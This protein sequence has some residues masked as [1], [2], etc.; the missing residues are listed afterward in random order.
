MVTVPGM[1]VQLSLTAAVNHGLM[2]A[3]GWAV[4][5]GGG[6]CL[7]Q[8]KR[9]IVEGRIDQKLRAKLGAQEAVTDV[10][11]QQISLV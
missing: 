8:R 3:L 4:G 6:R 5:G 2:L 7:P 9:E 10:R 11:S 1:W